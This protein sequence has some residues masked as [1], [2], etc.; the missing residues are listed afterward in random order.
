MAGGVWQGGMRGRGS[1]H[2]RGACV[3]GGVRGRGGVRGGGHTCHS[4]YYGIRSMS[5]RCASYWNA[6]LFTLLL[7][8][9]S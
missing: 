3:A 1:M 8:L 9:E 4:R 5:G 2:G 6:S 7:H